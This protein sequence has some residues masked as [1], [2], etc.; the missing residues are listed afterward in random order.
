MFKHKLENL[1]LVYAPNLDLN[2][3]SKSHS[4]VP[5]G[6]ITDSEIKVYFATKD[7]F[8]QSRPTFVSLQLDDPTELFYVHDKLAL[9]LG[10][11]GEFDENGAMVGSLI[12]LGQITHQM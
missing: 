4:Q 10:Q 6:V 3:W 7:S 9:Q 5:T 11:P 1:D 8:Q 2:V 12:V